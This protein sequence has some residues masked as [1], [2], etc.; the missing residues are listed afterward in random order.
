MERKRV[1]LQILQ[2]GG[3]L[4]KVSIPTPKKFRIDPKMVD[5]VFI[6]YVQNSNAYR[7]LVHKSKIL[8]I[9]PNSIIESRNTYFF[10]NIILYKDV[11]SNI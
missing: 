7:F 11:Q 10:E 8:D 5:C 3:C 9:Y 6:K 1:F 2:S 4:A